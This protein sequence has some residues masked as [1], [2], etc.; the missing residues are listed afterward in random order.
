M[1]ENSVSWSVLLYL[2]LSLS[3]GDIPTFYKETVYLAEVGNVWKLQD[4]PEFN[5]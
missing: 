3:L 4:A 1:K 2:I 5:P